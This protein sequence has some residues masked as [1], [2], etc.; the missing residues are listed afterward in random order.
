MGRTADIEYRGA[1]SSDYLPKTIFI[2]SQKK[3]IFGLMIKHRP[4]GTTELFA[5][6]QLGIVTRKGEWFHTTSEEIEE[7]VPGMLDELSLDRLIRDAQAWV[8]SADSLALTLLMVLFFVTEAWLAALSALAFHWLWY[9]YKSALA[10]RFL[11]SLF[12]YLNKDGYLMIISLVALSYLGMS[13]NYVAVALGLIFFFLMKLGLLNKVWNRLHFYG[14]G[15]P[16]LNDRMLNMLIVKYAIYEDVA[17]P[18]VSE[19]EERFKEMA[20]KRKQ[21]GR[22]R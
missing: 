13:G 19:M 17:P 14:K 5:E 3:D 1:T 10:N 6:T 11:G 21:G 7:Y 22:D 20:L 2:F 12:R 18:A 15:L 4:R 9:T 16:T 8:R